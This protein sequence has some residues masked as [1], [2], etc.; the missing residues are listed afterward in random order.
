VALSNTFSGSPAIFTTA[1]DWATHGSIGGK[2]FGDV[3]GRLILNIYSQLSLQGAPPR[4]WKMKPIEISGNL[5]RQWTDTNI[6]FSIPD[7]LKAKLDNWRAEHES[8]WDKRDPGRSYERTHSYHFVVE[9]ADGVTGAQPKGDD[10]LR[11]SAAFDRA[12]LE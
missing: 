6:D 3:Q 12:H 9:R 11:S 10:D 1:L 7:D 2:N 4:V 8:R 5:I